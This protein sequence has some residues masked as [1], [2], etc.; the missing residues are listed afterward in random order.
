MC[1]GESTNLYEQYVDEVPKYYGFHNLNRQSVFRA[2]GTEHSYFTLPADYP[3]DQ[4]TT[5]V[6]SSSVEK[7]CVMAMSSVAAQTSGLAQVRCSQTTNAASSEPM[8]VHNLQLSTT[9]QFVSN[10]SKKMQVNDVCVE[11][12]T[13]DISGSDT[14]LVIVCVNKASDKWKAQQVNNQQCNSMIPKAVRKK[15]DPG[16]SKSLHSNK[17]FRKALNLC[18]QVGTYVQQVRDLHLNMLVTHERG[19]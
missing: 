9:M 11:Y 17:S 15:W 5:S 10:M 14:E 4:D 7:G 18:N 8:L 3:L 6:S 19:K 16:A 2:D 13:V 12:A 1:K